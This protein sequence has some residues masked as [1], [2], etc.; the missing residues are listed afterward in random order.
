M[1]DG[2]GAELAEAPLRVALATLLLVPVE[3]AGLLLAGEGLHGTDWRPLLTALLAGACALEVVLLLLAACRLR[4]HLASARAP[5]MA[6]WV[7]GIAD[8]LTQGPPA[9]EWTLAALCTLAALLTAHA[10]L[11]VRAHANLRLAAWIGVPLALLVAPRDR[12]GFA[13]QRLAQYARG[14]YPELHEALH[15]LVLWRRGR[16]VR[17]MTEHGVEPPFDPAL[18]ERQLA[19]LRELQ[20]ELRRAR[21][22]VFAPE[23]ARLLD[24]ETALD[25][26]SPADLARVSAR[27]GLELAL[28]ERTVAELDDARARGDESSGG[29]RTT[30]ANPDADAL[31]TSLDLRASDGERAFEIPAAAGALR[32]TSLAN[33]GDAPLVVRR[34]AVD[35]RGPLPDVDA[36]VA[37]IGL[38]GLPPAQ[39]AERLWTHLAARWQHADPP[40]AGDVLHDPVRLLE[41]WGYGWCDDVAQAFVVLARRAGL[42]ARLWALAGHVVPEIAFDGGWHMYDPDGG[43]L[44]RGDD[45]RVLSVVDLAE[46]PETLENPVLA[47][48]LVA[49]RYAPDVLR[50]IFASLDDDHLQDVWPLP[51]SELVF[52]LRP[53]EC[54]TWSALDRGARFS[55]G[56]QGAP[57]RVGNGTWTYDVARPS[58]PVA[59]ASGAARVLLVPFD[60]PYPL[61]GGRIAVDG[62]ATIAVRRPR[63]EFVALPCAELDGTTRASLEGFVRNG[64]GQ[65]DDALELRVSFDEDASRDARVHVELLVQHAADA[66]PAPGPGRHELRLEAEPGDGVARVTFV[67]ER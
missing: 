59:E 6:L 62:R 18:L 19:R 33:A 20:M 35:G 27:L 17:A 3:V 55:D 15:E 29:A 26:A 45:G 25:D 32:A 5:A 54:M 9:L 38:A 52:T 41:V 43:V 47:E 66:F 46:H 36:I 10:L 30:D 39:A 1:R 37:S 11:P 60:L 23:D 63:G 67:H 22:D 8:A 61:L 42:E 49:P 31:T 24:G 44:Y 14:P 2:F 65:P 58:G 40:H 34:F 50:P 21:P 56:V 57:A 13:A 51:P 7:V 16:I 12:D 4:V 28:L 64:S 48:G 53:G